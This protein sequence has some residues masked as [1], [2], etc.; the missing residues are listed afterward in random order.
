MKKAITII[1]CLALTI[2]IFALPASAVSIP[3]GSFGNY[4]HVFIIGIDGA[5]R[6]IR[7]ANTPNFVR[8]F[9]TGSVTYTARAEI[10]TDSGPNWGAI[11]T[12]ASIIKTGLQNGVT[13]EQERSSDTE[14]PTIFTFAR[15]E[16]PDAELASFV[17]WNN[18]N[19]GIIENDIG[20]NKV[21]IPDDEKLTDAICDYLDAGN[22]P[23][24]MFVQLD[25]VDHEGHSHG[26][27]SRE[28]LDQ[29]NTVD[30]Y[31]GRIYDSLVDNDLAD[32]SLFIVVADHGHTVK[33]GHGGLTMRETNVTFAVVGK[34]VCRCVKMDESARN[35]DVAAV[36]LYALGIE[37]PETMT[38]RVPANVFVDVKGQDRPIFRDPI[39]ALLSLVL[40]EITLLTAW[41]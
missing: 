38:S 6:F 11:L 19:Y 23:K 32:S 22:A 28:F 16:Y 26:S 41:F 10:K 13:G 31:V 15:R 18:I 1:I 4:E 7:N 33:G 5:G 8:I 17:N 24:L 39:D 27:K 29:I 25:S 37:R 34:S 12:G 40:W 2:S 14:F 9:K 35:R 20:V 21:N 30:G 3:A 36:A